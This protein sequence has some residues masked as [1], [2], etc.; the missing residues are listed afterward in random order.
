M[1]GGGLR[2]LTH[3]HIFLLEIVGL[4]GFCHLSFAVAKMWKTLN[5]KRKQLFCLVFLFWYSTLVFMGSD[6]NLHR[7]QSVLLCLRDEIIFQQNALVV[8]I[9]TSLFKAWWFTFIYCT[10]LLRHAS[11]P[12]NEI[13]WNRYVGTCSFGQYV[14][15]PYIQKFKECANKHAIIYTWSSC[16]ILCMYIL[17]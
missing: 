7:G 4:G 17:N 12:R 6:L 10:M 15:M 1:G 13:L 5:T 8:A 9:K 3:N 2:L 16:K 14:D 11:I